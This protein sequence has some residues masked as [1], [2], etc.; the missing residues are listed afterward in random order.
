M[1][2]KILNDIK[3][4][5]FIA[6]LAPLLCLITL[7]S[8]GLAE[9]VC[10]PSATNSNTLSKK[11]S[12]HAF[13]GRKMTMD[14]QILV[15]H[16]IANQEQ[17]QIEEIIEHTFKEIDT[18][19]NKWNPESEISKINRLEA[20]KKLCISAKLES[21][22][23]FVD[24]VV[25]L[26]EGRFDPTIEPL[27]QLWKGHLE[28][29]IVPKEEEIQKILPSIG[30]GKIHICNGQL[31]KEHRLTSLDLGG[32]VKGYCVDLL[33]E[34]LV[35]AGF[36]NVMVNWEGE[37]RA[38]GMHPDKRPWTV[39][40]SRLDNDDPAQAIVYIDLHNQ[41]VATSGD[42]IQNWNV[43]H[44]EKDVTFFHVIDPATGRPLIANQ[45]SIAS[46]T[47]VAPN[48]AF[49]DALATVAMMFPNKTEALKWTEQVMKNYP[50]V[51]FKLYSRDEEK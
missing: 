35:K 49:A 47:V 34:R 27:Q 20:N 13:A 36:K 48:C 38:S 23:L 4:F 50:E 21:F 30:W 40:V 44:N 10:K 33:V 24:N 19:Y 22:L 41:S 14:Y 1:N 3:R 37:I 29:G 15:G 31:S 8:K 12:L 28:K 39:M 11:S 32:I 46:A 43:K 6:C 45:A 2:I 26:S 18:I 42:Y 9:A 25:R 17:D 51:H 7:P 5:V 16:E